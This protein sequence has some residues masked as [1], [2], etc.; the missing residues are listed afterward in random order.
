MFIGTP[1]IIWPCKF[2]FFL[3]ISSTKPFI[4]HNL[5][6]NAI[7]LIRTPRNNKKF[8]N[9]KV[10]FY[11]TMQKIYLK[12]KNLAI[13]QIKCS[14]K[15]FWVCKTIKILKILIWFTSKKIFL[16]K[17]FFKIYFLQW[18]IR[19]PYSAFPWCCPG[20]CLNRIFTLFQTFFQLLIF[21]W[22][23]LVLTFLQFYWE[24]SRCFFNFWFSLFFN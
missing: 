4:I 8:N 9:C 16:I 6:I 1:W 23:S 3:L 11:E 14:E 15:K 24:F 20:L 5:K 19:A 22:F 21:L 2:Y 18:G 7:Y 13:W 17:I 10:C 12:S